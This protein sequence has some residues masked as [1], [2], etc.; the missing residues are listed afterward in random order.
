[1]VP[2]SASPKAPHV[3]AKAFFPRPQGQRSPATSTLRNHIAE[4][5]S[6]TRPIGRVTQSRGSCRAPGERGTLEERVK[7][8]DEK[9]KIPVASTKTNPYAAALVDAIFSR[10]KRAS[11]TAAKHGVAL[12]VAEIQNAMAMANIL[13]MAACG[14]EDACAEEIEN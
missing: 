5:I 12:T 9:L 11:E 4:V 3:P 2:F 6:Q 14:E 13:V 1:M 8:M 10:V 7:Q